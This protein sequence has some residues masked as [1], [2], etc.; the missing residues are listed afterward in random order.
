MNHV[1]N[2][3]IDA[4]LLSTEDSSN[5]VVTCELFKVSLGCNHLIAINS[6]STED[7]RNTFVS[8]E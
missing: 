3:A 1:C 5:T 6:L 8:F 2:N 7:S 4:N